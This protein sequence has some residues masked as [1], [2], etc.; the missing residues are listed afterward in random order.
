MMRLALAWM[1]TA[2]PSALVARRTSVQ[3]FLPVSRVTWTLTLSPDKRTAQLHQVTERAQLRGKTDEDRQ[4]LARE[5][6]RHQDSAGWTQA[7]GLL[8]DVSWV[9]TADQSVSGVVE[10]KKESFSLQTEGSSPIK[11]E[12]RA[13]RVRAFPAEAKLVPPPGPK[14]CAEY[15]LQWR[16]AQ[17]A[18]V[19]AYECESK[20]ET[21][22]PTWP[23]TFA[24][25]P[26]LELVDEEDSCTGGSGLRRMR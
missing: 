5:L 8:K 11:L 25:A 26:G 9:V 3:M 1:L 2:Q 14:E 6:N 12:C 7:Q 13:A 23:A 4:V 20:G 10:W 19:R 21:W 18:G 22:D 24:E 17:A 15:E 16:P